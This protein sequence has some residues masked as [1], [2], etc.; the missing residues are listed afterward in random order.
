[1]SVAGRMP[2][3]LNATPAP[4]S[5]SPSIHTVSM[6][7]NAE[8]AVGALKSSN[9]SIAAGIGEA[10]EALVRATSAPPPA[11]TKPIFVEWEGRTMALGRRR[12]AGLGSGKVELLFFLVLMHS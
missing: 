2:G 1:M 8:G 4:S 9:N 3:G 7:S 12:M 6:A 11:S 5:R 10:L